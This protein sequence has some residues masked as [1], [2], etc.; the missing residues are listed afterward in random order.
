MIELLSDE[1]I[2]ICRPLADML[3][4]LVAAT[5]LQGV[6]QEWSKEEKEFYFFDDPCPHEKYKRHGSWR[7]KLALTGDDLELALT[8]IGSRVTKNKPRSLYLS[9]SE[10]AFDPKGRLV[11]APHLV[12]YWTD[13]RY[14]LKWYQLNHVLAR[15]AINAYA[16]GE[17]K[18]YLSTPNFKLRE[19]ERL[20]GNTVLKPIIFPEQVN[21]G[22]QS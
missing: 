10:P 12:L 19:Q 20:R 15:A 14:H 7:E 13:Y 3:G 1:E 18:N 8:K 22:E 5:L 4:S 21:D 9:D 17:W 6:I 2:I 11:N 16:L